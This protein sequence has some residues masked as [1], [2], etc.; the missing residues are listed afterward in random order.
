LHTNQ[1]QKTKQKM[2]LGVPFAIQQFEH[3]PWFVY[4]SREIAEERLSQQFQGTIVV[5]PSSDPTCLAVTIKL[6]D[7]FMRHSL[8]EH[9][10]NNVWFLDGTTGSIVFMINYLVDRCGVPAAG[11][12]PRPPV[13]R[14]FMSI[15]FTSTQSPDWQVLYRPVSSELICRG[16]SMAFVGSQLALLPNLTHIDFSN[17][18]LAAIPRAVFQLPSLSFL[19]LSDNEI[20]V[21][22]PEIAA[23]TSLTVLALRSNPL[24]SVDPAIGALVKLETLSLGFCRLRELPRTISRLTALRFLRVYDNQLVQLPSE[25]GALTR[26]A[27][28]EVGGNLFTE[29]PPEIGRLRSLKVVYAH[30]NKLTTLPST[31]G[32]CVN[33]VQLHVQHNRINKL[34]RELASLPRLQSISLASNDLTALPDFVLNLTSLRQILLHG[35]PKLDANIGVNENCITRLQDLVTKSAL[36]YVDL[37]PEKPVSQVAAAGATSSRPTTPAT[38]TAASSSAATGASRSKTPQQPRA[39]CQIEYSQ[40]EFAPDAQLLGKGATARVLA[41]TFGGID[42][43]VK[44]L[45]CEESE[46]DRAMA[47][48]MAELSVASLFNHPN[49]VQVLACAVAPPNFAIVMERMQSSLYYDLHVQKRQFSVRERLH[50]ARG[51]AAALA[52]VHAQRAIHRDIKSANVLLGEGG[53]V[54]VSDFGTARLVTTL[55]AASMTAN[56]GTA[57]WTAPE[58]LT[59]GDYDTCADVYSFGILLWELYAQ[60]VPYAALQLPPIQLG[61]QVAMKQL[62]P[63]L[64]VPNAPADMMDLAK[65][66]WATEPATRPPMAQ[67]VVRLRAA[68]DKSTSDMSNSKSS[69]SDDNADEDDD[70]KMCVVCMATKREAAMQCGHVALCV[71]C[72]QM[73]DKCPLCNTPKQTLIKLYL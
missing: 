35:N 27:E 24:T 50:V 66:C 4:V 63:T 41:A 26:L 15:P 56:V 64:P 22:P 31:I 47:S 20:T 69:V 58:V 21:V 17:N 52:F 30:N 5:R 40:L 42:V 39:T 67:V 72:G 33:I 48:M 62:R 61:M 8:L 55:T 44:L 3:K 7:G 28:L 16:Q 34:P 10:G 12:A 32:Q 59:G 43:A 13:S 29:L 46:S 25:V 11:I 14:E 60:Q 6:A 51:V 19:L 36:K 9:R 2:S 23:M 38:P 53:A 71:A 49:I 68:L 18:A 37:P 54:K 70:D 65:Q 57:Q 73:L 45:H 1:Q